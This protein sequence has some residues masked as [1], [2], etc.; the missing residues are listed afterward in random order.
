MLKELHTEVNR[1]QDVLSLCYHTI[2]LAA[3]LLQLAG[4]G[5]LE[6]S[7]SLR[8]DCVGQASGR[9]H[10][11]GASL[12]DDNPWACLSLRLT[13]Q[14]LRVR[15]GLADELHCTTARQLA[16]KLQCSLD[17]GPDS[18]KTRAERAWKVSCAFAQHQIW[19]RAFQ[20][21]DVDRRSDSRCATPRMLQR[22]AHER[23][24]SLPYASDC[25]R[26]AERLTDTYAAA[27]I[28]Q[29]ELT[30]SVTV[31]LDNAGEL[32]VAVTIEYDADCYSGKPLC[33]LAQTCWQP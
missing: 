11:R 7:V 26:I 16:R 17:A 5:S 8:S 19:T 14:A 1:N 23:S 18:A 21:E 9:L 4:E 31:A 28:H 25:V 12:V 29:L 24:C 10:S 22:D 27:S 32:E 33:T 2:F 30:K 3:L 13:G 15:C 6:E 20:E